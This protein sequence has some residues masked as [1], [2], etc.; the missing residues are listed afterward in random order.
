MP[1]TTVHASVRK[2]EEEKDKAQDKARRLERENAVLQEKASGLL[3]QCA[4]LQTRVAEQ[5]TELSKAEAAR[6][7]GA[8]ILSVARAERTL[9]DSALERADATVAEFRA[10]RMIL[11]NRNDELLAENSRQQ[12]EQLAYV[13]ERSELNTAMGVTQAERRFAEDHAQKTAALLEESSR[14]ESETASKL[15]AAE[16]S[17]DELR[18]ERAA[19]RESLSGAQT[20]VR[21]LEEA[22]VQVALRAAVDEKAL[23]DRAESSEA[24]AHE[25]HQA[26]SIGDNQSATLQT[27]VT[28]ARAEKK[29]LQEL[30]NEL[31]RARLEERAAAQ[32]AH[33]RAEATET[34]L[35]R[36]LEAAESAAKTSSKRLSVLET[37]FTGMCEKHAEATSLIRVLRTD[38][39]GADDQYT[40]LRNECAQL[41][42]AVADRS[43]S[44]NTRHDAL[45][46]EWGCGLAEAER[47]SGVPPHASVWRG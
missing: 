37:D 40:H 46:L 20:E 43:R 23:R 32:T 28:V 44:L 19:L 6:A 29:L 24:V 14:R 36:R 13:Q 35:R 18:A 1:M 21:L 25:A 38:L 45:I 5:A 2:L 33:D 16:A 41:E 8:E 15:V 12:Q 27:A 47:S 3:A 39:R 22:R 11:V 30:I 31:Q 10:E 7:E 26:K 17:L 34:E 9:V 42:C 4:E